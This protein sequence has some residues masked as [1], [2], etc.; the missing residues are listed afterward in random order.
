M[1]NP[2]TQACYRE[3]AVWMAWCSRDR[4][5]PIIG[6][7]G[8]Q[9]SGKSTAAAFIAEELATVHGLKA[10]VLSL[11]DFYLSR[12]A[13]RKLAADVHP[14][15]ATRGVPGTHEVALGISVLNALRS[16]ARPTLPRFSKA[17]DDR[18]PINE[19]PVAE[20]PADLVLFEGWCVGVPPQSPDAL[21][22]PVN[23]LEAR[24]DADGRW[25]RFVNAELGTA[26]REWFAQLDALIFLR[27]PDFA[28]VRRWRAQQE[29]DTARIA[30]ASATRLQSSARLERFI[31]HYERLSAHALRVLPARADVLLNLGEDH[32]V[33]EIRYRAG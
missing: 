16:G 15:L 13:R 6:I 11:D 2:R 28:C 1:L 26:Y 17:D 22:A 8:A 12:A 24:E 9:G 33:T 21:D 10:M 7:N 18:L 30:G 23:E 14:L 19:W 31:Q 32:S 25:R 5:C 27:V 20:G 3:L 4:H 29:Q